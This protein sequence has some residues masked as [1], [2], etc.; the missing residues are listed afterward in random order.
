MSLFSGNLVNMDGSTDAGYRYTMPKVQVKK[1]GSSKMKKSVIVNLKDVSRAVGRPADYL[2]TYLGQSLSASAKI[3][4]DSTK[5]PG[6][7]VIHK[8]YIAGHHGD[9][10]I[11]KLIL[12]FV[13]DTVMCVHCGN[14]ETTC[15]IEGSKKHKS[16]FLCCKSCGNRTSLDTSDRFVKYMLQH[17]PDN[18]SQGHAKVIAGQPT[19]ATSMAELADAEAEEEQKKKKRSKC[20]NCG[21]KTSKARCSKC[22]ATVRQEGDANDKHVC[23]NVEQDL[24]E[25][26]AKQTEMKDCRTVVQEWMIDHRASDLDAESLRDFDAAICLS[27]IKSTAVLERLNAVVWVMA[28]DMVAT[29]D[30]HE[31][32]KLQPIAVAQNME[33]L[34]KQ[35]KLLINS[36]YNRVGDREASIRGII[37]TLY[38][39]VAFMPDTSKRDSIVLGVLLS[40]RDHID[41]M[42]DK[43]L[44]AGCNSIALRSNAMDKFIAFLA[45][46]DDSTDDNSDDE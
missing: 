25:L 19:A 29:Y 40:F 23:S 2:L 39:A 38:Q 24:D 45:A 12:A 44:V 5:H 8:A 3:E 41:R 34:A 22:G 14:P 43:D 20:T 11:Q 7:D 16:L 28:C 15:G 30:D 1:E 10:I 37:S 31:A 6:E 13:R 33:Q 35:W 21:H 9:E 4:K 26:K 32:Q 27:D 17:P 36:L 18:A 42:T 46:G